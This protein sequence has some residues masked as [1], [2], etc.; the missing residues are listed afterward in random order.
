MN[1]EV[2]I[3]IKNTIIRY[4]L[5]FFLLSAIYFLLI[6]ALYYI[7]YNHLRASI[8]KNSEGDRIKLTVSVNE[9]LFNDDD[10]LFLNNYNKHLKYSSIGTKLLDILNIMLNDKNTYNL[11]KD[12]E[13]NNLD[14]FELKD[15][16]KYFR[17]DNLII[18]EYSSSNQK[19]C[20]SYLNFAIN[21]MTNLY[22][23]KPELLNSR[24]HSLSEEEEIFFKKKQLIFKLE[25]KNEKIDIISFKEYLYNNH[26][27][28]IISTLLLSIFMSFISIY[29]FNTDNKKL[30]LF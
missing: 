5:V 11:F 22:K 12:I 9:K 1:K 4:S 7:N 23:E 24:E 3:K 13:K 10:F 16:C 2:Y 15:K 26:N 29:I 19:I 6:L 14:Y 21:K 8:I 30:K 25:D 20:T 28:F 17:Y 27:K 18:I